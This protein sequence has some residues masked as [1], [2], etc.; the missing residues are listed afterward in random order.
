MSIYSNW[1]TGTIA[2]GGTSTG[3]IDLGKDYE[4]VQIILPTLTSCT[5]KVQVSD[6][7]GGT[8]QDLGVSNIT[9]TTTGGYGDVWKIG[10]YQFLKVVS[11]VAQAAA[12]TIKVRGMRY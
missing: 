3:V 6:T 7:V 1:K 9:N 5:L 4:Y 2:T 11:S 10:G 8:Y 12:R